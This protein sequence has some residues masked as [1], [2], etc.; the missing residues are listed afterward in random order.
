MTPTARRLPKALALAAL[1]ATPLTALDVTS[2]D[3]MYEKLLVRYV[4]AAGVRY[5]SWRSNGDDFK[6]L[7]Q[8]VTAYRATDTKS[9][10]APER[11]AFLINCH[12]ARVLEMILQG[13]PSRSVRDL[14]KALK[15]NEIFARNL[16]AFEGRPISLDGVERKLLD[17]YKD[18]RVLLA[19]HRA[20]KS[21]PPLRTE[22]YEGARLDAQLQEAAGSYLALPG[23]LEVKTAGGKTTIVAPHL[24]EAHAGA[25]KAG[26]GALAFLAA[27]GPAPV[28]EAIKAGG[29][30]VKLEFRPDDWSLNAVH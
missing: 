30:S 26:G 1:L 29:K 7:S 11:E 4:S 16:L 19:L 2:A 17:D 5:A 18:P 8:V 9:F 14:S 3:G 6:E 21:S 27:H 10:A 28:A 24:F 13:N 23:V 15:P 20:A 22:P 12:N 25:F